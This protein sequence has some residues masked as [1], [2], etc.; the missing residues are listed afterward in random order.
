M[1]D[2]VL[3]SLAEALGHLLLHESLPSVLFYVLVCPKV[4]LAV[5]HDTQFSL[6]KQMLAV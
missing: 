2:T 5:G 6:Y 1:W 3:N 4:L